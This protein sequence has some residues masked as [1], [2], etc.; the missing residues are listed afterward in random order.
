MI[1]NSEIFY[2][3]IIKAIDICNYKYCFDKLSFYKNKINIPNKLYD[4]IQSLSHFDLS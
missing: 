1:F 2:K 4:V 3:D